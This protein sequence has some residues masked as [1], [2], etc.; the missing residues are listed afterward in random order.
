MD[1]KEAL[2][3]QSR[4]MGIDPSQLPEEQPETEP[5]PA[6][7]Y[8]KT[9]KLNLVMERKGRAG[10]TATIIEGVDCDG[11]TLKKIATTLK[12]RL[13]T[14]GSTRGSEILIQGDRRAELRD[15]L[16][17]LGFKHISK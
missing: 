4:E 7:D 16:K 3:A 15:L 11:E 8:L 1:W 9:S 6:N 12:Q 13:G 2:L 14:G 5:A 10:K 17:E